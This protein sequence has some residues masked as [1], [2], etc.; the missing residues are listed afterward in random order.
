MKITGKLPSWNK[1]SFHNQN[2]VSQPGLVREPLVTLRIQVHTLR[3]SQEP[4]Q[5][6]F[7]IPEAPL[8]STAWKCSPDWVLLLMGILAPCLNSSF[9]GEWRG[10]Y[11]ENSPN[12]GRTFQVLKQLENKA[13]AHYRE[14]EDTYGVDVLVK[15]TDEKSFVKCKFT[16]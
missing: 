1:Q 7:S 5:N 8:S 13:N 12:N 9:M 3:Y 14:W 4:L 6:H 16:C 2:S 15:L 11:R 10:A